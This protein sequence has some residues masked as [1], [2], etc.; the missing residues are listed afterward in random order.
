MRIEIATSMTTLGKTKK[1]LF[2]SCAEAECAW[3]VVAV[4]M[5]IKIGKI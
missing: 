5:E 1:V 3:L 4:G 2:T